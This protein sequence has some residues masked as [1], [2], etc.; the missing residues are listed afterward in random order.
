[1]Q[2]HTAAVRIM[3]GGRGAHEQP[4]GRATALALHRSCRLHG[5]QQP[6]LLHPTSRLQPLRADPG[7]PNMQ[8]AC[9][10]TA[11]ARRVVSGTSLAAVLATALSSAY[12]YSAAGCVELGAAALI[13]PAAML[14][15]PLGARLTSRLDCTALRRILGYFLLAA[16]PLVPL[17]AGRGL[18]AAAACRDACIGALM[19]GERRKLYAS[20]DAWPPWMQMSTS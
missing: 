14:T 4:C 20:I 19:L 5:L 10:P 18:G 16:A 8:T 12:T 15:A 11:H 1:M 2:D 17:K 9:T 6:L 3:G 7:L 13:S